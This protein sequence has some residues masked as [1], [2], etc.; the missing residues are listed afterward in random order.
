MQTKV[1]AVKDFASKVED[2]PVELMRTIKELSMSLI[3]S[4][5]K[6]RL[7][8]DALEAFVGI[9]QKDSED[10]DDYKKRFDYVVSLLKSQLG[11][12]LIMNKIHEQDEDYAK[13]IVAT[14]VHY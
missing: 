8:W 7:V 12:P 9:K 4:R 13:S 10:L 6:Y 11:N 3:E 1:K 14:V 5:F 2:D